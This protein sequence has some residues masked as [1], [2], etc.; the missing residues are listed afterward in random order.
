MPDGAK[1]K[2]LKA[3]FHS[4]KQLDYQKNEIILRA[5][6]TP[7][8]VYLI[9]SGMI[10]I[11]SLTKQADEHVHHFFG[12]DDF[13]P[14]IWTFRGFMRNVYYETLEP[15]KIWLVPHETFIE[16]ISNN[17]DVMFEL[18]EEMVDRYRLYAGR[19]DNLLYSDA[20][21]RCTYRLLGLANRF[22][23]KTDDHLVINATIT[24]EDLAHSI[25]MTRETFGRSLGRLQR[26]NIIGYDRRH[27]LVI[28]DLPALINIIGRDETETMWPELMRF[29]D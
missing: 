1:S 8:G 24:H 22:G 29:V 13:F 15:T 16:F 21:E 19:I 26:K 10:K 20:R 2:K 5:N 25:N 4:G 6:D 12:P 14:M 28:K 7:R 18:L 27:R 23:L 11:Y 3:M 9:G 17:R